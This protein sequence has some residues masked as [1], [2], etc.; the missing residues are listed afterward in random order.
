MLPLSCCT[1]VL[2]ALL[3]P[4][5][6]F[7]PCEVWN[8]KFISIRTFQKNSLNMTQPSVG[9]QTIYFCRRTCSSSSGQD[10]WAPETECC[11]SPGCPGTACLQFRVPCHIKM[12]RPTHV[13]KWRA[14]RR[15]G[16]YAD[17]ATNSQRDRIVGLWSVT[18]AMPPTVNSEDTDWAKKA[19]QSLWG[20]RTG[21]GVIRQLWG[22]VF[23]TS[24][25]PCLRQTI[26][27]S[28]AR[29]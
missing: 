3:F 7:A 4:L 6:R 25:R 27:W 20:C 29:P 13:A 19:K 9:V 15:E 8:I 21:W 24:F 10:T 5:L 17:I 18:K 12:T 14:P 26:P 23:K 28:E 1:D 22:N 2:P 16:I 11:F